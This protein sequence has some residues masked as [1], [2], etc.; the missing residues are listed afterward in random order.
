M[1]AVVEGRR[2]LVLPRVVPLLEVSTP[3]RVQC[4]DGLANRQTVASEAFRQ[5]IF[6][7]S[8]SRG[9]IE[10]WYTT[11]RLSQGELKKRTNFKNLV[12]CSQKTL[13]AVVASLKRSVGKKSKKLEF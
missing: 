11:S 13:A 6:Y 10:L 7:A 5:A 8:H 2:G 3:A 9:R 1:R 4:S 12:K